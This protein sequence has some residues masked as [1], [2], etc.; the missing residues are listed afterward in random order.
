M[1]RPELESGT[2]ALTQLPETVLH[3]CF[4]LL[5]A[6]DLASL[7]LQDKYLRAVAGDAGLWQ[8]LALARWP[9]AAATCIEAYSSD[10]H[11]LYLARAPLPHAVP[12]AADR[13][14]AVTDAQRRQRQQEVAAAALAADEQFPCSGSSGSHAGSRPGLPALAFE[15]V[16]RQTFSAGLACSRD[17]S[18]RRTAEWRRLKEDLTWWA[19]ERPEVVVAFVRSSHD[20][21]AAGHG[22]WGAAAAG[23]PWKETPWR[24]SA[25]AFLQD[26]GLLGGAHVSVANRVAAEAAALDRA[27]RTIQKEAA[28]AVEVPAGVPSSHWWFS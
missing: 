22:G 8:P 27:I 7:S 26:L 24:R 13:V 10:W 5:S 15:D 20:A 18:V 4:S 23:R 14:R 19:S 25:L 9:G 17:R 16:M 6:Q 3:A 2:P 28:A 12:L 1:K 11:A 21:L